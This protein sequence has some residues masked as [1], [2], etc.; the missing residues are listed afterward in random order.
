MLEMLPRRSVS[1]RINSNPEAPKSVKLHWKH[2]PLKLHF[3]P[4]PLP[5][6]LPCSSELRPGESFEALSY[7]LLW[8][9]ASG[10][11]ALSFL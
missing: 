5:T 8:L 4:E 10:V 7:G 1:L 11:I 2:E 9:S 3:G 6:R